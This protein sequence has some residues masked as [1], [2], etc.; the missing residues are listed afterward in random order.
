VGIR[1]AEHAT[2]S[3]RK[4]LTLTSPT[5]GGRSVGR[6]RLRTKATELSFSSVSALLLPS[7]GL[8]QAHT[9]IPQK[10]GTYRT[11][12]DSKNIHL[13]ATFFR[14]HLSFLRFHFPCTCFPPL[15]LSL[16]SRDSA[17]GRSSNP[18][19][20]NNFL[21]FTS[22][23]PAVGSTQPPIQ[24]VPAVLSPGV[25]RLGRENDHSPRTNADV[26]KMCIYISTP[27]Y[28]VAELVEALSFKPWRWGRF[29]PSTSVFPAN[30]HSICFST[31][32][33]TITGKIGQEWPQCQ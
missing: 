33:F 22:S 20:V 16:G 11:R 23:R 13:M 24:W 9:D 15:S 8:C 27:P 26:K 10:Q 6:F 12:A 30:V 21:F 4:W 2:P 25:K 28:A 32:I 29:Y 18:D 3:T 1:C 19:M 5:S 17:V 7:D 14:S 31:I